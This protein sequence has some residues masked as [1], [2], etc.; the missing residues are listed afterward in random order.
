M[1]PIGTDLLLF[2]S[3]TNVLSRKC[4]C[5]TTELIRSGHFYLTSSIQQWQLFYVGS[6]R[7]K[8]EELFAILRLPIIVALV[9]WDTKSLACEEMID[10]G[11]TAFHGLE[12]STSILYVL[13]TLALANRLDFSVICLYW[14]Y[15][16]KV[17]SKN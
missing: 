8:V 13:T 17:L 16:L 6:C 9:N 5:V 4:F 10:N 7:V 14:N 2:G 11:F 12:S 1:V 3:R 15:C